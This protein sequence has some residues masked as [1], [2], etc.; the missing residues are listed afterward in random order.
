MGTTLGTLVELDEE[1]RILKYLVVFEDHE[2]NITCFCVEGEKVFVGSSKGIL[3][4]KND[5]QLISVLETSDEIK[6]IQVFKNIILLVHTY[7]IEVFKLLPLAPQ[8]II[9]FDDLIT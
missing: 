6:D 8:N 2:E 9:Q 7:Q 5:D 3:Y 4:E 1:M